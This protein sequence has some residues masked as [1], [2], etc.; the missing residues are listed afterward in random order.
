MMHPCSV[1]VRA[2]IEQWL[3]THNT[4]PKT[5]AQHPNTALTPNH[6]LRNAIEKHPRTPRAG[7]RNFSW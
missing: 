2:S 6:E 4:S 5:G 1:D 3:T 7:N